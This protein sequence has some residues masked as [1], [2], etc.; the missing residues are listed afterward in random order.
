M[1]LIKNPAKKQQNFPNFLR[2]FFSKHGPL[3]P[4]LMT[5]IKPPIPFSKNVMYVMKTILVYLQLFFVQ[6]QN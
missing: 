3:R 5:V 4:F 6:K 2:F 1:I